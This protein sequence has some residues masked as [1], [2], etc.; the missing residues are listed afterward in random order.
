MVLDPAGCSIKRSTVNIR[1]NSYRLEDK[2]K[3][4]LVRAE[5]PCEIT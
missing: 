3:S 4:G 2:L 1:G 5:E